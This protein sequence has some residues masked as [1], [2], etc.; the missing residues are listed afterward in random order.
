LER[1][2]NWTLDVLRGGAFR[3]S[4]F[5]L[6]DEIEAV[7]K[8]AIEQARKQIKEQYDKHPD[9]VRD[10]PY[11]E[12]LVA[13]IGAHIGAEPTDKNFQ[14]A[15]TEAQARMSQQSSNVLFSKVEMSS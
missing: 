6:L 13:I 3:K 15:C 7:L 1:A 12:R 11:L 2:L 5:L 10:D 9:L 8:P 4:A 14:D